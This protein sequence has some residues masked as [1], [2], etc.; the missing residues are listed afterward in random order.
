MSTFTGCPGALKFREG[1]PD[2]VACPQCG[3]EMETWS[4]EP[5]ARCPHCGFWTKQE[6]GA[7]CIDWCKYAA[8]CIGLDKYERLMKPRPP[9]QVAV[10]L[11]A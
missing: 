8:E 6:R 9:E 4:D 5:V 7:S 3:G 11:A 2:Y 10:G 1:R